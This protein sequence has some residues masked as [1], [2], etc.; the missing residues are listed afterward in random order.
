MAHGDELADHLG[1]AH[2]D[3]VPLGEQ[4]EREARLDLQPRRGL[5]EHLADDA[6]EAQLG[7]LAIGDVGEVLLLLLLRAVARRD[8]LAADA[9]DAGK[10]G[11]SRARAITLPA[12]CMPVLVV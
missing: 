7:R 1:L 9:T 4:L 2:G 8:E 11:G 12:Q 5:L 10:V 3:L 6:Q